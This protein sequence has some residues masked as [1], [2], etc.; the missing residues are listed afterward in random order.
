MNHWKLITLI[1]FFSLNSLGVK[2]A[3]ILG[4]CSQSVELSKCPETKISFPVYQNSTNKPAKIKYKLDRSGLGDF[5]NNDLVG[6]VDEVFEKWEDVA[7]IEFINEGLTNLD[8]NNSNFR[9]YLS[10]DRP[11]GFSPLIMDKNGSIVESLFGRGANDVILGLATASFYRVKPGSTKFDNIVESVALLNGHL[12]KVS[13]R[14]KNF[15]QLLAE[16]ESTLLH[17]MGHA[18]GL[19][20]SQGAFVE[21]FETPTPFSDFSSFPVM[22]PVGVNSSIDLQHDDIAAI[23]QGYPKKSFTN[24]T[25]II[26]GKII[27]NN[28]Q[29]TGLNVVAIK[30]NDPTNINVS[31]TTDFNGKGDGTFKITGLEPGKYVLKI[32][33]INS[34]FEGGSSVGIHPPSQVSVPSGYYRKDAGL[35][36]VQTLSQGLNQGDE[37]EVATGKKSTVNINLDS[38]NLPGSKLSIVNKTG[39]D[40]IFLPSNAISTLK[41]KLKRTGKNPIKLHLSSSHPE[42][43]SFNPSHI[44]KLGK[45][46]KA[47]TVKV[48]IAPYEQFASLLSESETGALNITIVARDFDTNEFFE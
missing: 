16:L 10:P 13:N 2:A 24:S 39:I 12:Y 18:I 36:T 35:I 45:K 27:A 47:K 43:V 42:L 48:K 34:N 21:E 31:S 3:G 29:I 28:Q 5:S 14:N 20:H 11:L 15:N 22:F 37:V 32:E 6:I 30:Q 19:D 26:K 33:T 9:N 8:I 7:N 41:F 1:L 23:N 38:L 4:V 17:E 44:V 25:G 40:S 46:K